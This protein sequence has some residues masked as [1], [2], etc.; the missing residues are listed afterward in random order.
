MLDGT[1]ANGSYE[2][3]HFREN[4]ERISDE[5]FLNPVRNETNDAQYL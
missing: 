2:M 1:S 4:S 5:E 3:P